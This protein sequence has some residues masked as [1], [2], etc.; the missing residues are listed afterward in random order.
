MLRKPEPTVRLNS[1]VRPDQKAFIKRI[2][3]QMKLSE[4]QINRMIIDLAMK[5]ADLLKKK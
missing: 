3:K 2:A 1:H 4:G 5:E